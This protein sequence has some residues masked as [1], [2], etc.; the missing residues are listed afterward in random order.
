S[1]LPPLLPPRPFSVVLGESLTRCLRRDPAT[2]STRAAGNLANCE[3]PC[4]KNRRR[5][6]HPSPLNRLREARRMARHRWLPS[7]RGGEGRQVM[8]RAGLAVAA[9]TVAILATPPA[10]A[11]G[12]GAV[13]GRAF[14]ED[15]FVRAANHGDYAAVCRL[16]STHYLRASQ[17]SCRSLY[18]WG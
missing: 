16:Y 15:V 18:R 8:L 5:S 12:P 7:E 2:F 3:L 11:A 6:R 14:V 9:S 1:L 4:T 13:A 17:A 10:F